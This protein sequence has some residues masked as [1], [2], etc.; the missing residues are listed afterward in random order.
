M[1]DPASGDEVT[2][3]VQLDRTMKVKVSIYNTASV[4]IRTLVDEVKATDFDTA[5]DGVNARG[6]VIS[7]GIY[8]VVIETEDWT[9]RKKVV[10]IK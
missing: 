1:F 4:L 6:S 2:I 8:I 7:S 9:E 10:V 3:Q 5:W